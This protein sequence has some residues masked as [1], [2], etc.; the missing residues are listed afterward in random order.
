MPPHH[1]RCRAASCR[2]V[3]QVQIYN[4]SQDFALGKDDWKERFVA[5]TSAQVRSR[6]STP[7]T[8]AGSG[9][10][11]ARGPHLPAQGA[12]QHPGHTCQL[13]VLGSNLGAPFPVVRLWMRCPLRSLCLKQ[14]P[15]RTTRIKCPCAA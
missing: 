6:S 11:A 13:K 2:T 3:L 12:R 5:A 15:P 10:S 8:L 1:T 4:I 9:C 7:A 14:A